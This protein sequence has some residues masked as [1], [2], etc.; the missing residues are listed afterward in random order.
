MK[1]V[2]DP[3]QF[4]QYMK[5]LGLVYAFNVAMLITDVPN[6]AQRAPLIV[7]NLIRPVVLPNKDTLK[8]ILS[9]G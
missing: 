2:T 3:A 4:E 6:A 9:K 5:T 7:N 8:Y 1:S